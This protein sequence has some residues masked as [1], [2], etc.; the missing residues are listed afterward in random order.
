MQES[1]SYCRG[2][3]SLVTLH[4]IFA[5]AAYYSDRF[6]SL[7]KG[8]EHKLVEDGETIWPNMRNCHISRKD[9]ESAETQ[10][11]AEKIFEA[12]LI[13]IHRTAHLRGIEDVAIARLERNGEI[14]VTKRSTAPKVVEVA[15]SDGVQRVQIAFS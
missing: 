9:L 8:T 11:T 6:G 14:S 5:V 13:A 15:V 2:C 4:W 12:K 3:N 10:R 1:S 7:V